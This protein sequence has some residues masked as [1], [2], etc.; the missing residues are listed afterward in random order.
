ML[1]V[2]SWHRI[3]NNVKM[4]EPGVFIK[5]YYCHTTESRGYD[6]VMKKEFDIQIISNVIDCS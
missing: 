4:H 6:S 1:E 3:A 2:V 5:I